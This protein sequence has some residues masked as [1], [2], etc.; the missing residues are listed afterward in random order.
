MGVTQKDIAE[1]IGVSTSTVSRALADDPRITAETTIQV[2][3]AAR[4]L[5]YRFRNR[6]KV[7]TSPARGNGTIALIVA[8]I[9]QPFYGE[10][11]RGVKAQLYE[12]G[13]Q[14]IMCD[15]DENPDRER[16]CLDLLRGMQ[17]D[18][19][20]ITPLTAQASGCQIWAETRIPYV[21]ID[22]C[23]LV[24]GASTV[25]VDHVEGAYLAVHHLI[26][27][28]HAHIA[29]V[30]GPLTIPPV[31]MMFR[32][33][34]RALAEAGLK[35]EPDWV[36]QEKPDME[37]GYAGMGKLLAGRTPPTAALFVSDL[38][39]VAALR[40][41]DEHG[42]SVPQDFSIVGYDDIP[43]AGMVTPALTTVAQDKYGLGRISA[44][45]LIHEIETGP[46]VI[47]QKALLQPQLIVRQSTSGPSV[48]AA[49]TVLHTA[50]QQSE[51]LVATK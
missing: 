6:P 29:F 43:I 33:Y 35:Y 16:L 15:S 10:L 8:D 3:E 7:A 11:A 23:E 30:G 47:H 36:C 51:A 26:G 24:N 12:Q 32:G 44:R 34:R 48:S 1:Q 28:G 25:S 41:L 37:G 17:V 38:M 2:K 40:L 21:L 18:G 39:A 9:T 31:Q 20:L 5:G 14:L 45:I 42:L 22:A 50:T 49:R 27:L 46:G 19:L 4:R 13:Y